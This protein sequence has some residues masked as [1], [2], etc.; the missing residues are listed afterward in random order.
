MYGIAQPRSTHCARG[1]RIYTLRIAIA[2]GGFLCPVSFGISIFPVPNSSPTR[3]IPTL[4]RSEPGSALP[5]YESDA[6]L[7]LEY[8]GSAAYTAYTSNDN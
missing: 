1:L 5:H 2:L 6:T 8:F 4:I 7:I 3:E